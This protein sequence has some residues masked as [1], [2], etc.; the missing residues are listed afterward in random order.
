MM[1]HNIVGGI[2][3]GIHGLYR[4]FVMS[5]NGEKWQCVWKLIEV[6]NLTLQVPWLQLVEIQV[7]DEVQVDLEG[8]H[9]LGEVVSHQFFIGGMESEPYRHSCG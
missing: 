8:A 3:R 2:D 1:L 5:S 6:M 4:F 7:A 9:F